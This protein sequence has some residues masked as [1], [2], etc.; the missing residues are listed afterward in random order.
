MSSVKNISILSKSK[1]QH[2]EMLK[3]NNAITDAKN[4]ELSLGAMK[5]L[6]I[7]LHIYNQKKSTN[8]QIK[9]AD[10]RKK[11][12]L[13]KNNSYIARIK[14]YL[15]ELKLPFELRDFTDIKSGKKISWAITS[16]LTEVKVYKET[17][18]IV[19]L[20]ISESFLSFIID[21]AGYTYIN[22]ELTKKFKTKYGYK[23]YEMYTRYYSMPNKYDNQLAVIKMSLKDLND[24][25][26]TN[27][28]YISKMEEGI[29]RGRREILMLT[30]KEIFCFYDKESKK[31]IFSWEKNKNITQKTKNDIC[32]IPHE[33]VDELVDWIII[34]TQQNIN[35]IS[36][37]RTKIKTLILK[38]DIKNLENKYE[39][40]M[41]YKY[42]YTTEEIS[43][44][45]QKNGKYKNFEKNKNA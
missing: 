31:F 37:Y 2:F 34:H 22:L 20:L 21:R 42:G 26:G 6:D 41:K 32:I 33:R 35:N 16:F 36:R 7:I 14:D 44:Y 3:K 29:E 1:L 24:K 39:G 12:G 9:L 30:K 11:L 17:Q 10:L 23:I 18:Q 15:L 28:K 5:M 27:H 25:F 4:G 40:M 19:E 38:N 43:E 13:E 45:K 8:L